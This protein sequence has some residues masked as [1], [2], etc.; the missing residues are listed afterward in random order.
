MSI[1]IYNTGDK[2]CKCDKLLKIS[3]QAEIHFKYYHDSPCSEIRT[4]KKKY[5]NLDDCLKIAKHIDISYDKNA[6][7]YKIWG[8][9]LG[10][11]SDSG[12]FLLHECCVKI[13]KIHT[14]GHYHDE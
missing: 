11:A 6:R 8:Y 3:Y 5:D 7:K 10:G 12:D 2:T 4:Y 1:E 9:Y 13:N 14:Y